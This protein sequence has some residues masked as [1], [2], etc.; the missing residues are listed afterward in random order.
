MDE[1]IVPHT[2]LTIPDMLNHVNSGQVVTKSGQPLKLPKVVS[3]YS[4]QNAFFYLQFPDDAQTAGSKVQLRV[5]R[6]TQRKSKFNPQKQRSKFVCVP[7]NVVEVGNHFIWQF[8]TGHAV[9][10]PT[11]EG[12]LHHYRVCEFG[13]DDCVQAPNQVDRTL[14][15]YRH[16]LE[17]NVGNIVDKLRTKCSLQNIFLPAQASSLLPREV[18]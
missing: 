10:V 15:K 9:N 8:H 7:R 1:L 18:R 14:L 3:S 16:Q 5:L 11:K 2:N 13:G 12:F 4:F 17:R 6:K